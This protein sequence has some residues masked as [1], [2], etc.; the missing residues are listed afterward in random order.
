MTQESWRTLI[1]NCFSAFG[2]GIEIDASAVGSRRLT[3][4]S[5]EHTYNF[6]YKNEISTQFLPL[7]MSTLLQVFFKHVAKLKVNNTTLIMVI[8]PHINSTICQWHRQSTN[9][10][11]PLSSQPIPPVR[12]TVFGWSHAVLRFIFS[13]S[14]CAPPLAVCVCKRHVPVNRQ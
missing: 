6:H 9:A 14:V 7:K 8:R 13:D 11:E 2:P 4:L 1:E 5:Q 10:T 12:A 3:A